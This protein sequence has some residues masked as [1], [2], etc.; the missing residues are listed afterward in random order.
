MS[1]DYT[2]QLGWP[3]QMVHRAL[4]VVV[5]LAAWTVDARRRLWAVPLVLAVL[6]GVALLPFDGMVARWAGSIRLGG[7]IRREVEALQQ[8]GQ[9]SFSLIAAAV[10]ALLD[11]KRTRR[12]LDWAVALGLT[13]TM[14]L[15]LKTTLG[16][17]RPA[18]GE[19]AT[20]L[21]P[22]G[23]RP[24]QSGEAVVRPMEFGA[25]GVASLWSMPSSHTAAAV[26]MSVF[27][28]M[29][30]PRL[31]PLVAGLAAVVGFGRLATGAHYPSDV[32]VGSCL[33]AAVTGLAVSGGWGVRLVDWVWL[34][35]VD[36]SDEPSWPR[37]RDRVD[38]CE[39]GGR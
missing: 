24:L 31:L 27:L 22:L 26:V 30:Y 39:A 9:L 18:Y 11:P 16:R 20:F 32:L 3:V 38:R 28:G 1:R 4:A 5:P 13:A 8:Y 34:R 7:D 29:L 36:P 15:V 25:D 23:A 33:G 10:I 6:G 17:P 35:W 19:P 37:V 14:G 21:G 2:Q 12:L